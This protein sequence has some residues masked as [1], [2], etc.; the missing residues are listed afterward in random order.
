MSKMRGLK[1]RLLVEGE[2][3]RHFFLACCRE[4][5]LRDQIRSNFGQCDW[6][7]ID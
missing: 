1:K 7:S 2:A 6:P 5:D 3:D 4:A